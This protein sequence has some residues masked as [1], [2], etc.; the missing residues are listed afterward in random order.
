MGGRSIFRVDNLGSLEV[1]YPVDHVRAEDSFTCSLLRIYFSS[2]MIDIR[3]LKGFAS[4]R[5]HSGSRLRNVLLS[6][7]DQLKV[8][9]FLAKMDIWITLLNLETANP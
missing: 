6:E 7:R 2:S 1:S 4:E 3:R 5:L 8:N 9:D